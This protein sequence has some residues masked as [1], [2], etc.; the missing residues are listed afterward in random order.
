MNKNNNLKL[1]ID[2]QLNQNSGYVN[3]HFYFDLYVFTLSE[4]V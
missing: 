3:I 1:N 4:V 2:T